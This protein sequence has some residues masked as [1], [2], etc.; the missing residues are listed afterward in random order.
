MSRADQLGRAIGLPEAFLSDGE[1]GGV[2]QGSASEATLVAMLA[3]RMRALRNMRRAN[4]D[5][6]DYDLMSKMTL[7]ASDQVCGD[8]FPR[9]WC[10]RVRVLCVFFIFRGERKEA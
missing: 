5:A 6:S 3:A 9:R 8:I 7:Y 1:G 10:F 2:I 4:P